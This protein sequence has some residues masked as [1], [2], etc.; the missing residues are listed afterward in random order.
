MKKKI[1]IKDIV[2]YLQGNIRY[3][4]YYSTFRFLILKH[5]REQITHR[6]RVMDGLCYSQGS[7]KMCGCMTTHLQMANKSCDKPCYPK[8][9]NKKN[10]QSYKNKNTIIV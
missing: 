8:M 4:L 1:V 5:I 7:C 9:M 3:K 6:I 10:W 2:A